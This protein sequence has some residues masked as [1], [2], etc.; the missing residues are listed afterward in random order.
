MIYGQRPVQTDLD[1]F[2]EVGFILE[3]LIQDLLNFRILGGLNLQASAIDGV[4]GLASSI[5]FLI[6]QVL[7][8]LADQFV[9]K[10]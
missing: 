9:N 3:F 5:A 10:V 1:I 2:R 8:D 6:H 4:A 7:F